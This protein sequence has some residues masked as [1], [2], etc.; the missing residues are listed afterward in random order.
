MVWYCRHRHHLPN[1]R[2]L[3]WRWWLHGQGHPWRCGGGGA[4]FLWMCVW[5]APM[6]D[7]PWHSQNVASDLHLPVQDCV[8][9]PAFG[10]YQ[11]PSES[12]GIETRAPLETEVLRGI[13]PI[14]VLAVT[15]VEYVYDTELLLTLSDQLLD[16]LEQREREGATFANIVRS[17]GVPRGRQIANRACAERG[18]PEVTDSAAVAS[19]GHEQHACVFVELGQEQRSDIVVGKG[20]ARTIWFDEKKLLVHC[21]F[22]VAVSVLALQAMSREVKHEH[23]VWPEF[24]A[25]PLHF[26]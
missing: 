15:G 5:H 21:I 17:L 3:G 1:W 16:R 6:S 7:F 12:V 24:V 14:V 2:R 9:L 22:L 11:W 23:V 8:Y 13:L 25:K 19:V 26:A 4:C 20:V 18:S 10:R